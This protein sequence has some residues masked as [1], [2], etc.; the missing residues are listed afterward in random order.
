MGEEVEVAEVGI[1]ELAA[2]LD[3]L[4]AAI[5]SLEAMSRYLGIANGAIAFSLVSFS[6]SLLAGGGPLDLSVRRL[7]VGSLFCAFLAAVAGLFS[8]QGFTSARRELSTAKY[9]YAHD[10]FAS[11]RSILHESKLHSP[12]RKLSWSFYFACGLTGLS[13]VLALNSF[14][15]A[16]LA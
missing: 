11:A 6:G 1:H 12:K 16:V 15:K 10:R 3:R 7:I 14:V 5:E 9:L 2:E 4:D 8:V 13:A